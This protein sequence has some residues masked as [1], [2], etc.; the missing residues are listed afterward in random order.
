MIFTDIFSHLTVQLPIV[1]FGTHY[2]QL[3]H[4]YSFVLEQWL[5]GI[6]I[7]QHQEWLLRGRHD[8]SSGVL[9]LFNYKPLQIP[10]CVLFE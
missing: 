8:D 2:L 7:Q 9:F 10:Y 1:A 6:L 3:M 4:V 5:I